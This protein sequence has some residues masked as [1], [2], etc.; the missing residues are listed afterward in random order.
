LDE[1]NHGFYKNLVFAA[2]TKQSHS[3][4]IDTITVTDSLSRLH[5]NFGEKLHVPMDA[6]VSLA[7]FSAIDKAAAAQILPVAVG[8]TN[9]P[10]N[11]IILQLLVLPA[12]T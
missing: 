9:N 3:T 6:L 2:A 1:V 12:W 8:A 7:H 4:K 5:V 10:S 11:Q